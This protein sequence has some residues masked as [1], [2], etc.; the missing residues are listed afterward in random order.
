MRFFGL[1]PIFVDINPRTACFDLADAARKLTPN[2]RAM[3]PMHAWGLM[4]DM[5]EICAFGKEHGL[6]ICED[7][8]HAHGASLQDKKSGA[9]GDMSIFSLQATKPLPAIE[10]GIGMYQTRE[11]FERSA[12]FGHYELPPKLAEDSPYRAYAGTGFGQKFRMHPLSAAIA[13]KQLAA[14]DDTNAN[15]NR[16]VRELN[17]QLVELPGFSEP[18]CRKDQKRVYYNNNLFF[19]DEAKAGFSRSQLI[20]AL[21]AEGVS[22]GSGSYPEQHKFKLYSEEKWWHHKPTLPDKL[23]GTDE[24]NKSCI[25]LPLLHDDVPGF[26]AQY[27]DA[28]KKVWANKDKVAQISA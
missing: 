7:A 20:K 14:L 24:V 26:A 25:Y 13:R 9:W 17:D 4:C 2:T 15:I 5:D 8:A 11:H 27:A 12:V 1:V 3:V 21:Q 23:A 28:F 16:R 6:I 18:F 10:G 22:A 19:L